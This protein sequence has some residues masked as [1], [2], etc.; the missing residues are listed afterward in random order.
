MRDE[1]LPASRLCWPCYSGDHWRK[2]GKIGCLERV[3][4]RGDVICRCDVLGEYEPPRTQ[5]VF[6]HSRQHQMMRPVG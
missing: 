6:G 3:G 2:H 4:P 5:T 1:V